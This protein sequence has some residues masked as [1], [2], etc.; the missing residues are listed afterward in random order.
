MA[1]VD[2]ALASLLQRLLGVISAVEARI[3]RILR[4]AAGEGE[5]GGAA[6]ADATRAAIELGDLNGQVRCPAE[7]FRLLDLLGLY[8]SIGLV[9][10]LL[11]VHIPRNTYVFHLSIFVRLQCISLTFFLLVKLR[12]IE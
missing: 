6:V 12:I 4:R 10:F 5:E 1:V 8:R 3:R 7:S 2:D 9:C 11:Y